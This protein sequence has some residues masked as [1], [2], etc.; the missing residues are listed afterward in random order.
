MST[1]SAPDRARAPRA[2][3]GLT[4]RDLALVA[5]FCALT[6]AL[7]PVKIPVGGALPIVL[8]NM[9]VMLTGAVLGARRGF[10]SMLLLVVLALAGLPVLGSGVRGLAVLTGP[11][12]GFALSY[13]L[14]ALVTGWVVERALPRLPVVVAVLA[15]VLGGIV[16]SYAFGIPAMAWR[17]TR[18][19]LAGATTYTLSSFLVGDL[20]KAVVAGVVAK[21]VHQALPDLLGRRR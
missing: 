18:L 7:V 2:R 21:A 13:P 15:C 5:A 4:A 19:T 14:V 16:V 12:V 6:V 17:S 3:R 20:I 1:A 11:S 8:Q 10:L 9:G